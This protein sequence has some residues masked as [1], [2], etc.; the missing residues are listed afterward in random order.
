MQILRSTTRCALLAIAA[1]LA[2]FGC[3]HPA[4][5]DEP[6]TDS[7]VV[8]P[9]S[10]FINDF[11]DVLDASDEDATLA[12]IHEVKA[13]SKG[14]IVVVILRSL[15]GLS[16]TDAARRIGNS[17][18]VGYAGPSAD[19][20]T[21]TGV[22]VLLAPFD[23]QYGL[24]LGEGAA[25]FI[26][27]KEASRILAEHMAPSLQTRAYGKAIYRTVVAVAQRFAKRF[28]FSL[29]SAQSAAESR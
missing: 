19:P 24:E 22:V 16:A 9:P 14:E 15:H 13:K 4:V 23:G 5:S 18:G 29:T 17:W 6:R 25:R 11:A 2:A 27:D 1:V 8:P 28:D 10:G 21:R 3:S 26:S 12:V 7:F 20:A